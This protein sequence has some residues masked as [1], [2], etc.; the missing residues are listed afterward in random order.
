MAILGLFAHGDLEGE[1]QAVD[2]VFFG[3]A[4]END[5][6][7]HADG[8]LA[9]VEIEADDE[10]EPFAAAFLSFVNAFDFDDGAD[11]AELFDGD[12]LDVAG[13]EFARGKIEQVG[14]RAVLQDAF[15]LAVAGDFAV[16]MERE[17]MR[18]ALVW[19]CGR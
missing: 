17:S 7:D 5:R 12:F 18:W 10:G 1:A 14:F 2:E 8:G 19:G 11:G 9:G 13:E 15:E 16:S 4:V 3:V 6:V